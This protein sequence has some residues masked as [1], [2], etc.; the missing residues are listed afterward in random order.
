MTIQPAPILPLRLAATGIAL[1]PHHVTSDELD[2][3]HGLAKGSVLWQSGVRARYVAE[4]HERQST[5]GAVALHDALTRA[6]LA[7]TDIDCLIGACG[8][9]EQ[10][11]PGTACAIAQA[12]CLPAGTPA[13]D[14][15]ASCLSFLVALHTAAALI[16]AGTYRRIA[17]VASDLPSRGV[18]WDDLH[19]SA[20]FG[21]GAGAV[22]VEAGDGQQG[23]L[24]YG[25]ATFTS[26]RELCE[27]RA[28]GTRIN[29]RTSE[30]NPA[31][32][33]F[34]MD[35]KGLFRLAL[36]HMPGFVDTLLAKAGCTRDDLALIVPHQ[37]SLL[38]MKHM[39]EALGFQRGRVVDIYENHGNQVAASLACALHLAHASDRV[40][41]GSRILL[42]GTAA[43]VSI[44][45]LVLAV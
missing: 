25:L 31:D 1:P 6:G 35:G 12:A 28:G 24:A 18:N 30:H 7:A 13:F 5:L 38:A 39:S 36:Q 41:S 19:A 22:I 26:G 2:H 9:Q 23:V 4:M 3:R 21:D 20:I 17:V 45:G 34:K 43:G 29:P 40:V 10:A 32:Y 8:V 16:A 44:G 27:V 33:L 14:V 42:L 11:L 15:N 37:A